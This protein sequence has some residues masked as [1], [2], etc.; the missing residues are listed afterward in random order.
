VHYLLFADAAWYVQW[1][2]GA[3]GL[4]LYLGVAAA[5][6]LL[7]RESGFTPPS[8][9]ATPSPCPPHIYPRES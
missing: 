1:T 6:G 3:I 4:A 8:S 9:E 5:C 2:T 7:A